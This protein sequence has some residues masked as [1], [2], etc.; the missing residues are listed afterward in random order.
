MLVDNTASGRGVVVVSNSPSSSSSDNGSNSIFFNLPLD[1]NPYESLPSNVRAATHMM[2]GAAAGL[3]EHTIMYPIDC[4]KTR[5]QAL[6][7]DPRARYKGVVDGLSQILRGEGIW[8]TIRGINAVVG[9]AGPAHALYFSCYEHIKRKMMMCGGNQQMA[10]VFAAFG[11]TVLHDAVMNPADVIKQRMQMFN[12]PYRNCSQCM[13]EIARAEGVRAFYRSYPTQ[14]TMN[15]PFQIVH[16]MTYDI[17]QD[18]LNVERKYDPKTHVLSGALAGAIAATCTMPLDVCKT[19]LNTQEC[20]SGRHSPYISG[21]SA[22]FRTV[23]EYQGIS[24]YFRGLIARVIFQIPSTAISWS[25]YEFF[26]FFIS[27]KTNEKYFSSQQV[28]QLPVHAASSR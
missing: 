20:C 7:P 24:G 25:V 28:N 5:M 8:N 9:G 21:L 15:V 6:Q 22:A 18:L 16:F 3:L 1:D 14:L 11:A 4:V 12:S 27:Q 10:N 26:K 19:L 23:Y 2:A 17:S 13:I